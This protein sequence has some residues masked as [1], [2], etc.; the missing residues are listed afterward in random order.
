[1]KITGKTRKLIS[2]VLLVAA[3]AFSVADADSADADSLYVGDAGDNS[4]KS[5]DASTGDF[6]GTTVKHA[7]SGLHGP[8]GLVVNADGNLLV[9]DQN[10]GTSTPGDVL[11]YSSTTGK[12]LDRIVSHDDPNAPA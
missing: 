12:L 9:S 3:A 10:V 8:R 7:L 6:L 4:V 5:F 11:L 1:M 2:V